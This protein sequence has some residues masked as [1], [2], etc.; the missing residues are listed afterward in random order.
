MSLSNDFC[1]R[2]A[3]EAAITPG[4]IHY[5]FKNKEELLFSVQNQVQERYPNKYEGKGKDKKYLSPLETLQEIR[6][7]AEKDLNGTDGNRLP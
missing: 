2:T 7:R 1:T 6:S 3:K 5:Y 4:L